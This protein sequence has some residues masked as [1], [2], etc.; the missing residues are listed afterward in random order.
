MNVSIVFVYIILYFKRCLYFAK[1][2]IMADEL[3]YY[4]RGVTGRANYKRGLLIRH[5][6]SK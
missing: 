3:E 4:S 2:F 6:K 1:T 5:F